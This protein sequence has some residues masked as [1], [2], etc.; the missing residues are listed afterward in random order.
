MKVLF[1]LALMVVVAALLATSVFAQQAGAVTYARVIEDTVNVRNQPSV[2]T[3]AIIAR[4]RS[5]QVYQV[6]GQSTYGNWYL[7]DLG[8]GFQ[9]WIFSRLVQLESFNVAT[10]S[11]GEFALGAGGGATS[12]VIVPGIPSTSG[13]TFVVPGLGSGGGAVPQQEQFV[14]PAPG[15]VPGFIVTT[16]FTVDYINSTVGFLG[17]VNIRQA[18]STQSRILGRTSFEQRATPIG[19]NVFATWYLVNYNGLVGWVSAEYVAV[20][21]TMNV[22]AWPVVG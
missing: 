15:Q 12:T 17:N 20:P 10:T 14:T 4:V 8:A 2:T 19:R 16:G 3:G 22:A 7:I 11:T 21:P 1:R 9:G 13:Q 5:G 6:L 18:P